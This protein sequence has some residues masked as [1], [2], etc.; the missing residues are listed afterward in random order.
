MNSNGLIRRYLRKRTDLSRIPQDDLDAFAAELNQRPDKCLG[1]RM[2]S[3]VLC[4]HSV[5]PS[6]RIH[7]E[8][9]TDGQV[10]TSRRSEPLAPAGAHV[11]HPDGLDQLAGSEN[12]A[13]MDEITIEVAQLAFVLGNG[14]G[15][16]RR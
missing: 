5:A 9:V 8:A 3:E 16:L 14:T 1:F 7:A 6:Y 12:A 2:P 10:A 15:T 13:V 11:D 4:Q